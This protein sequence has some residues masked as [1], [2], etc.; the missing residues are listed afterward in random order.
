MYNIEKDEKYIYV[1]IKVEPRKTIG[2]KKIRFYWVDGLNEAR[3]MFPDLNI[4]NKPDHTA[5]VSN[6]DEEHN[7]AIWKFEIIEEENIN[8][9]MQYNNVK[10]SKRSK[11][12][13][14]KYEDA[15]RTLDNEQKSSKELVEIIE[16]FDGHKKE[17]AKDLTG[18]E[19][20]DTVEETEQ[21]DQPAIV[22][23]PTE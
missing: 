20:S 21:S 14:N 23:E 1:E 13:K 2:E 7:S 12:N 5:V 16:E 10:F 17:L 19:K 3:K 22:Q 11:K 4:K 8:K 9:D 15:S 18:P 6:C